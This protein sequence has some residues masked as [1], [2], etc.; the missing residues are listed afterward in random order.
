VNK[1]HKNAKECSSLHKII[2][3]STGI[4]IQSHSSDQ[5][6]NECERYKAL[7]AYVEG[8]STLQHAIYVSITVDKSLNT[9]R[10]HT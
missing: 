5:M 10:K 3:C 8:I 1:I 6:F 9:F 4:T 7:M 2:Q